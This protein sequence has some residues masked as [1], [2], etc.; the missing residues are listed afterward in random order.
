MKEEYFK[1]VISKI[2]ELCCEITEKESYPKN[3]NDLKSIFGRADVKAFKE[4]TSYREE[5]KKYLY[6]LSDKTL[7][8]ICAMMDF[9]R[10]YSGKVLPINL[11]KVFNKYYLPY[12]FEQNEHADK[13]G[14]VSYLVYKKPLAEYLKRAEF[15]LFDSKK[16]NIDFEHDCGGF[17]Y[18]KDASGIE[19][20][21]YD[22][23]EL[24]L[25]CLNCEA[26]VSKYVDPKFLERSI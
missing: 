24:H 5:L 2:S 8:V 4:L 25:K 12:W 14:I 16:A 26:E 17:L 10:N 13:G 19:Q 6:N 23:Y 9:G 3:S 21:D 20:I 1:E 18:L 7:N 22:E 11:N 15:I